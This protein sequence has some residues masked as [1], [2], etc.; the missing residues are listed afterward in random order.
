MCPNENPR[1]SSQNL[2]SG[3]SEIA[4]TVGNAGKSERLWR[5]AGRLADSLGARFD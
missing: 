5:M 4:S 3:F 1:N 2:T